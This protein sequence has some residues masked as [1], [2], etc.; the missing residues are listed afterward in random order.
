M[1][2]QEILPENVLSRYKDN[3]GYA[4]ASDLFRYKLLYVKGGWYFDTDCLL[5]RPLTPLFDHD[6]VFARQDSKSV[7]NAVMKFPAGD[8]VLRRMYEECIRIGPEKKFGLLRRVG[9]RIPLVRRCFFLIGGR[10]AGPSMLT[11]HLNET[12][13]ISYALSPESFYPIHWTS[14]KAFRSPFVLRKGTYILHLWNETLRRGNWKITD[15]DKS[16]LE[17]TGT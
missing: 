4:I 9:G 17:T 7:N 15:L 14:I 6:Y 5:L 12:G 2:A 3:R 11:R 8:P 13:L 16:L 10:G 1:D